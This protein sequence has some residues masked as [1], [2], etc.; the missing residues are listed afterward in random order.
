MFLEI[1]P[2]RLSMQDSIW[3]YLFLRKIASKGLFDSCIHP[4]RPDSPFSFD[5][6]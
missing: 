6:D 3:Y 1:G 4:R 2:N 5:C